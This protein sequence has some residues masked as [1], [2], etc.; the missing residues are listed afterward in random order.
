MDAESVGQ[1]YQKLNKSS[2]HLLDDIYHHE[3]IFEDA[4]HR[5]EGKLALEHYFHALYHNVK[6]CDFDIK[7]HQQVGDTGFL[8]WVMQLEH[9]KLQKGVPIEVKGVTHLKFKENKVIY[10]RDYFDLGEML[11]ENL[12]LLGRVVKTIKQRLGQ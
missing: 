6:R 5:I 2:L 9:P 12:P 7:T 1:M 11:Y 10:H 8:V 4:A 3:V